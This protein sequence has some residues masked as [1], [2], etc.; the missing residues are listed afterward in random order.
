MKER[1]NHRVRSRGIV[2]IDWGE[3]D[4]RKREG[5]KPTGDRERAD[6]GEE[7]TTEI[8]ERKKRKERKKGHDNYI[9]GARVAT[10]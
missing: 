8:G 2:H 3:G 9:K 6:M 7:E 1:R 4:R 5:M 10:Y